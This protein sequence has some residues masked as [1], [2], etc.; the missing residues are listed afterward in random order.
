MMRR[1]FF[2][3]VSGEAANKLWF[4]SMIRACAMELALRQGQEILAH[5]IKIKQNL[6]LK[7]L[8]ALIEL[9]EKCDKMVAGIHIFYSLVVKEL[10]LWARVVCG[11]A[12]NQMDR[13]FEVLRGDDKI[14]SIGLAAQPNL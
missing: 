9:N 11:F 10:D 2:N 1:L 7:P 12:S 13:C 6:G 5:T 8:V 14:N 4:A 3:G